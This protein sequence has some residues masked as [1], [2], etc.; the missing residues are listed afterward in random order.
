M[1]KFSLSSLVSGFL[2][3]SQNN[4][5]F[6]DIEDEFQTGPLYRNN[7]TG[8]PNEMNNDLDMNGYNILNLGNATVLISASY[9]QAVAWG[10]KIV[11]SP[12]TLALSHVYRYTEASLST[13]L[14]LILDTEANQ[15]WVSG[16]RITLI[17]KGVGQLVVEP[18]VGVTLRYAETAKTRTRYSAVELSYRG[19]DVWYLMGDAEA[20]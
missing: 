20:S 17:Q 6:T 4:Q 3:T 19:S 18:Q 11:S 14:S 1:A 2:T 8:E 7:P 10:T 12:T 13:T 9:S 16:N 15:S 5:N